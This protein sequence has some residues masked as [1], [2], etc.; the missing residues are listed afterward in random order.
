MKLVTG[1]MASVLIAVITSSFGHV[2]SLSGDTIST[3]YNVSGIMFSIGM[4]LI[5]TSNTSDVKNI[6]M[7]LAIRRKMNEIRNRYLTFFAFISII[8]V[9]FYSKNG[10][11]LLG[12][13][14]NIVLN[15]SD[16]LVILMLY[17]I[18]YFTVNFLS[19]RKLN[20]EIEDAE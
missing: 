13:Y 6:E 17:S 20:E 16:L 10:K 7:K 1:I 18:F 2:L 4:S 3:L 12:I 11:E 15:V 14:Q 5:V 8:Y 19:L 9:S